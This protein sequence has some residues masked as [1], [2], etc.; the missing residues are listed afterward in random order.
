MLP[1]K[2]ART[3]VQLRQ[4]GSCAPKGDRAMI[5]KLIVKPRAFALFEESY[6]GLGIVGRTLVDPEYK[7][8]LERQNNPELWKDEKT[9]VEPNGFHTPLR[10]EPIP[11]STGQVAIDILSSSY[12]NEMREFQLA[13]KIAEKVIFDRHRFTEDKSRY[14]VNPE[15]DPFGYGIFPTPL[16]VLRQIFD[17]LK[18]FPDKPIAAE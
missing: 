8:W 3:A 16:S 15:S 17:I 9:R 4:T 11:E 5:I 6:R 18:M 7:A 10:K 1:H 2:P 13:L 14:W 12:N